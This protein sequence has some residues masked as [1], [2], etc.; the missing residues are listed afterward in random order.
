MVAGSGCVQE[1]GVETRCSRF[2]QRLGAGVLR[3]EAA[4]SRVTQIKTHISPPH[5]HPIIQLHGS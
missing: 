5:T 4:S 1:S 2:D 3:A